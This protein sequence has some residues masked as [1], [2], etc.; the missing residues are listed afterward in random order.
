MGLRVPLPTP[1]YAKLCLFLWVCCAQ[2]W[3]KK[4]FPGKF[5]CAFFSAEMCTTFRGAETTMQNCGI[6]QVYCLYHVKATKLDKNTQVVLIV[7]I[8]ETS[9]FIGKLYFQL[10]LAEKECA[11]QA[12][13]FAT[14]L[15]GLIRIVCPPFATDIKCYSAPDKMYRFK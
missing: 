11:K 9:L 5:F 6:F 12:F 1:S 14:L 2:A 8:W 7:C 3:R 4:S 15:W 13:K 10:I